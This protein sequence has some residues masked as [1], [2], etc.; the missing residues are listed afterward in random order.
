MDIAADGTRLTLT[1]AGQ[2]PAELLPLPG[3]RY[4]LPQLDCEITFGHAGG[5]PV[6][7]I[8]Q[9]GTTQTA[10]RSPSHRPG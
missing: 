2:H 1:A 6:M 5:L 4:R 3:G 8:R 7:H 10:T 9:E